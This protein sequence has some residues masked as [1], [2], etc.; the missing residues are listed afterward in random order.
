M[1]QH[2]VPQTASLI[3]YNLLDCH[4]CQLFLLLPGT[5]ILKI[6]SSG[7]T[8]SSSINVSVRPSILLLTL[9]TPHTL[10]IRHFMLAR[11]LQCDPEVPFVLCICCMMKWNRNWNKSIVLAYFW[12]DHIINNWILMMVRRETRTLVAVIVFWR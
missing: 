1:K 12:C 7:R 6:L 8:S 2:R 9:L 3:A 4:A 10:N 5:L 11:A